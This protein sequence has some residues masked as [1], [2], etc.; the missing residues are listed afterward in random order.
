MSTLREILDPAIRRLFH[1]HFQL[2]DNKLE[3]LIEFGPKCTWL[4]VKK[5][6]IYSIKINALLLKIEQR[7][8]SAETCFLYAQ[9]KNTLKCFVIDNTSLIL[10]L[11]K[12]NT[13]IND[14]NFYLPLD[15]VLQIAILHKQINLVIVTDIIFKCQIHKIPPSNEYLLEIYGCSILGKVSLSFKN[16]HWHSDLIFVLATENGYFLVNN[17]LL[18]ESTNNAKRKLHILKKKCPLMAYIKF[19]YICLKIFG[20][21]YD[22]YRAIDCIVIPE[23]SLPIFYR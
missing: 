13:K 10:I 3:T 14:A 12:N 9:I 15:C 20:F 5:E 17:V 18:K 6:I 1:M 16:E 19:S 21:I 4:K 11:G 7:P 2:I 23:F 8:L 22:S